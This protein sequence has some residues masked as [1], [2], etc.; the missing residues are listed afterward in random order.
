[1][2]CQCTV[3]FYENVV[4]SVSVRMGNA[5]YVISIIW[6]SIPGLKAWYHFMFNISCGMAIMVSS[7]EQ[8]FQVIF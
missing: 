2:F 8:K 3:V 5:A 6:N 7:H 4:I 1:M